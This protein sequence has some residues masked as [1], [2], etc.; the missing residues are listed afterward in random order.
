[1]NLRIPTSTAVALGLLAGGLLA[2]ASVKAQ[3]SGTLTQ[4]RLMAQQRT[5][6]QNQ[7]RSDQLSTGALQQERLMSQQRIQSQQML[8]DGSGPSGSAFQNQLQNQQ[9]QQLQFQQRPS[10]GSGIPGGS[11]SGTRMGARGGRR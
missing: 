9:R 10:Q 1:M 7:L 2:V 3:S 8:R 4:E 11:G 5:Q 6:T